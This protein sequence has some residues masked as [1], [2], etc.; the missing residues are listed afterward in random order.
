[1]ER[2]KALQLIE[3][4]I[5][6]VVKEYPEVIQEEDV[7]ADHMDSLNVVEIGI[8]LERELDCKIPDEIM[9][10]WRTVKNIVDTI[11]KIET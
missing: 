5:R 11:V 10:G 8:D 3:K 1:M 2:S 6:K 4:A 9:E 7:L